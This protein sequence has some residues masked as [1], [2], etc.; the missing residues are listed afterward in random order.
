MQNTY[1]LSNES[2]HVLLSF[3]STGKSLMMHFSQCSEGGSVS[4]SANLG[5]EQKQSQYELHRSRITSDLASL[6]MML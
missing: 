6:R 4:L 5:Q 3:G 1:L 2:S